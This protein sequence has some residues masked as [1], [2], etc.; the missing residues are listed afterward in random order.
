M[1]QTLI[2]NSIFRLFDSAVL[3]KIKIE[4][5]RKYIQ[6]H[7]NPLKDL[8][9]IMTDKNPNNQEQLKEFW[10]ENKEQ[11]IGQNLDFAI[12]II[13]LKVKDENVANAII[14]LLEGIK[15]E[16]ELLGLKEAA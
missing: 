5:L 10:E 11:L 8:T 12:Q 6:I 4:A 15:A 9:V 1:F 13:R 2:I 16:Q 7:L 14:D 3:S